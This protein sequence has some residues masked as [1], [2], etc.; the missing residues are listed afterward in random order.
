M[1]S[2]TADCLTKLLGK[3]LAQC[4]VDRMEMIHLMN[5]FYQSLLR[6]QL[7]VEQETELEQICQRAMESV[8]VAA[9]TGKKLAERVRQLCDL[10][11][12][13]SREK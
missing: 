2:T 8:D 5:R 13:A 7:T 9:E 11:N 6:K 4:R 12:N 10:P 1:Q 3:G